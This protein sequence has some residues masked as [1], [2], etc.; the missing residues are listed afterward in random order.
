MECLVYRGINQVFNHI[1][2][3]IFPEICNGL[4]SEEYYIF[5]GTNMKKTFP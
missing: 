3:I 1:L 2:K 5:E 4:Y